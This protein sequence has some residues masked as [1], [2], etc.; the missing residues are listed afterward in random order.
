MILY[1]TSDGKT[2][3]EDTIKQ[4]CE[5]VLEA[6]KT[7]LPKEVQSYE[8]CMLVIDKCKKELE[9]KQICL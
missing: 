3:P 4:V 8:M 5:K 9:T 6:I 1:K 7:G 2:V